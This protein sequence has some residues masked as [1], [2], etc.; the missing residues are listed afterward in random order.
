[1]LDTA[2]FRSDYMGSPS[3]AHVVSERTQELKRRYMEIDELIASSRDP[4]RQAELLDQQ[5]QIEYRLALLSF[6]PEEFE[7]DWEP[8]GPAGQC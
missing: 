7:R 5:S 8:T 3:E 2:R 6:Y 1:V 4:V